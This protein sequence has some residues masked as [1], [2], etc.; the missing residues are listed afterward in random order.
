M[1]VDKSNATLKPVQAGQIYRKISPV[2]RS[3]LYHDKYSEQSMILN[4]VV[5]GHG[6]FDL[7]QWQTAMD[8]VALVHPGARLTRAWKL[9]FSKWRAGEPHIP[10]TLIE[11]S[12]WNGMGPENADFLLTRLSPITGPVCE[13][14]LVKSDKLRIVFRIHHAVSDASGLRQIIE[15]AFRILRGEEPLGSNSTIFDV[16]MLDKVEGP[17]MPIVPRSAIAPIGPAR[18]T[19]LRHI[20]LRKKI[21]VREFKLIPKMMLAIKLASDS[22]VTD[23]QNS[24]DTRIRLTVDLR[25]HLPRT[26]YT[27]AN[28]SGAFDIF[29]SCE[30]TIA[31][32]NLQIKN[33]LRENQ[34][35]P[36]PPPRLLTAARWVP[37]KFHAP[38]NASILKVHQ[39][40]RYQRSGAL[41]MIGKGE[42]EKYSAAGFVAETTFAVPIPLKLL[43]FFMALWVQKDGVEMVIGMPELLGNDGRLEQFV[44][45][46]DTIVSSL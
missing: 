20:W 12:L 3:Y 15:D 39:S 29:V 41:T 36:T 11:D 21:P 4:A 22:F 44:N 43:P 26:L 32:L 31:D 23:E 18:G 2:E 16:D 42:M 5:E 28:C 34:E 40:G 38:Y 9:G 7:E 1:T 10:V 46:L 14:L 13:V 30:D 33:F 19:S 6:E 45:K 25:R 27:T 17:A 8:K 24:G 37:T 35:I